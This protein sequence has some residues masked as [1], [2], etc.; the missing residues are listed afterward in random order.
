M[1]TGWWGTSARERL[2]PP[3][4]ML[5]TLAREL[6]EATIDYPRLL[7]V[8]TQSMGAAI[9]DLCSLHFVSEDGGWLDETGS[10]YHADPAVAARAA[11]HLMS[12]RI[13]IGDGLAGTVAAT[14]E[15]A[16]TAAQ[17]VVPLT[18]R[19]GMLGIAMLNRGVGTAAYTASDLT[20]FEDAALHAALAIANA[21]LLDASKRDLHEQLLTQDR[22][23]ELEERNRRM[24]E[25]TRLKS[26]F[27]ANMSHELRTPLNAVIGFAALMHTGKAGPLAP[28]HQEYVG[29]I[30]T[31]SRHL[32]Q[33]INDVLDLA[34][35]E[36]GRMELRVEAIDLARTVAEA[37]DIVRGLAAERGVRL[38]A[39]VD[40]ALTTVR[41]DPRLVK[42]VLYN[43]LSN[44]I[45]FTPEG[46]Q[47]TLRIAPAPDAAAYF[48]I[49]VADTGIG[50]KPDDMN[51]LFIEFQQ[52]DQGMA[53]R[54]PGTGLGLALTKRIVEAQGGSVSVESVVGRGSTFSAVL[55]RDV[56]PDPTGVA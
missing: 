13:R 30:L 21:R 39:S 43:Y 54:Y 26:E 49:D 14:G 19:G 11:D 16:R 40:P 56:K 8:F 32:L 50:I 1:V 45:K 53:K 12:Q 33:L 29:D 46:G 51:H 27:L 7:A 2:E 3:H 42:Q 48:Q 15:A 37:R 22:R 38:R 6:A 34:K 55:P 9:G 23:R 17:L 35:V 20:L 28:A 4:V 44:A 24:Q 41:V 18:A 31:S 5:V 52:L 47:V 10:V 36:S 25:A